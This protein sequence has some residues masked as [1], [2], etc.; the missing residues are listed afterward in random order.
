MSGG[1]FLSR[2]SRLKLEAESAASA[3][4]KDPAAA[5][6]GVQPAAQGDLAGPR[7]QGDDRA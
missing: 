6:E 2:W 4:G 3:D 5:D 1:G 7:D